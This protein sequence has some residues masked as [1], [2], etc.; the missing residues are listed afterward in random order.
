MKRSHLG[1][2]E[3]LIM[4][5]LDSQVLGTVAATE[6]FSLWGRLLR[7][8]VWPLWGIE[9]N[10]A[11]NGAGQW[12]PKAWRKSYGWER[13]AVIWYGCRNGWLQAVL[14]LNDF[15]VLA[16][17]DEKSSIDKICPLAKFC[18]VVCP[19]QVDPIHWEW[20]WP[21]AMVVPSTLFSMHDQV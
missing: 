15:Y 21:A 16:F 6:G 14:Q 20:L 19:F 3:E 1:T 13:G 17:C 11:G 12:R 5:G 10:S 4:I 18:F 2:C 8:V 7:S 9:S